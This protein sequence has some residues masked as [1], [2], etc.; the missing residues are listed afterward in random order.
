MPPIVESGNEIMVPFFDAECAES[1]VHVK[2]QQDFTQRKADY[3][4]L[5]V[6]NI[7]TGE[8]STSSSPP[9]SFV[10]FTKANAHHITKAA[11]LV[12][13]EGYKMRVDDK[14]QYGQ[15]NGDGELRFVV[16]H[17]KEH[18]PYQHRFVETA[19]GSAGAGKATEIATAL[20]FGAVGDRVNDLAQAFV[21]DY[22]HTF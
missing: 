20:G 2:W 7:T 6:D 13:G 17:D 9:P 3:Y 21:G 5:S 10:S 8:F 18:K 16:Y 11:E 1:L 19:L 14:L 15:K 4:A 22:L 12:E